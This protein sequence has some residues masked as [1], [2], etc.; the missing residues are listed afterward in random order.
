VTLTLKNLPLK[1][2]RLGKVGSYGSWF[3][4]YLCGIDIVV[5]R[6]SMRRRTLTCR[7]DADDQPA[8]LYQCGPRCNG[9]AAR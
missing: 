7:G 4:F 1:M 6:A 9:Q 3:Q 5:G 8:D 2:E